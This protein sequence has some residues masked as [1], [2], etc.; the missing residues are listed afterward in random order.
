MKT[1]PKCK[2]EK[3]LDQFGKFHRAK[4]G[5]ITH[6]KDCVNQKARDYRKN[7]PEI[8]ER[9]REK[10]FHK[11][12]EKLGIDVH[13]QAR[14]RP[15]GSGYISRLGY[16]SYKIKNHPCADKN[17]RVQASH[18][19][20]YENTGRILKKGEFVHHINGDPL[21]NRIENLEVWTKAHPPGQRIED[22]INWCISFLQENGYDIKKL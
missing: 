18:L 14:R 11:W 6:C 9:Q 5:H 3:N 15:K 13:I 21:D 16:M 22:K 19:A 10:N 12:R 7:N 2:V 8:W 1:C 4:D 17:G 20:V